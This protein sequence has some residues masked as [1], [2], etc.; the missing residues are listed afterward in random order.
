MT[1]EL[2]QGDRVGGR[3][4]DRRRRR[5]TYSWGPPI[6]RRPLLKGMAAT[7]TVLAMG[8]VQVLVPS[9][10]AYAQS[11]PYD[12][13]PLPCPSYASDHECRPG[14]GPSLVCEP[15]TSKPNGHCCYHPSGSS[16]GFHDHR[17]PY[18]LRPNECASNF[19]DGWIW[20]QN[21]C[22]GC[23]YIELRCHDGYWQV[24]SLSIKTICRWPVKCN[25][26][27]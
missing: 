20:S 7:A 1:T 13:K 9:R 18:S 4:R 26:G 12:I 25:T 3:R 2:V 16:Q 15:N 24:G 21:V 14:C 23:N 27:K 8:G 11:G 22:D 19:Y 6:G 5:A 10:R 17:S